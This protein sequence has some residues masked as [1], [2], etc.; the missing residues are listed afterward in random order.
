VGLTNMDTA[1]KS[2]SARAARIRLTCP[3]CSAPIVG[4]R[5]MPRPA[6]RAWATASRTA[7]TVVAICGV[8]SAS[9]LEQHFQVGAPFLV[10]QSQLAGELQHHGLGGVELLRPGHD[11]DLHVAAD[12]VDAVQADLDVEALALKVADGPALAHRGHRLVAEVD[13]Q[14]AQV[15]G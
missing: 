13:Q 2:V 10:L 7:S 4:T 11:L 5:P 1:T 14:A 6:R 8:T 12:L 9:V 3:S 15:L